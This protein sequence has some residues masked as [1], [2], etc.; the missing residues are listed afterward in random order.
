MGS[1]HL[2][3]SVCRDLHPGVSREPS[4]QSSRF[5]LFS[6]AG[7]VPLACLLLLCRCTGLHTCEATLLGTGSSCFQGLLNPAT[8]KQVEKLPWCLSSSSP[9][10]GWLHFPAQQQ[11]GNRKISKCCWLL[12]PMPVPSRGHCLPTA[13]YSRGLPAPG[14]RAH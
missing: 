3:L 14:P 1:P 11:L 13:G 9:G 8:W 2:V 12:L 5:R 7:T 6:G 4:P 10:E